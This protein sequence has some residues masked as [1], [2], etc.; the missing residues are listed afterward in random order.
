MLEW[1]YFMYCAF[2]HREIG[3]QKHEAIDNLFFI[4]LKYFLYRYIYLKCNRCYIAHYTLLS[5][6]LTALF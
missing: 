2:T 6:R 3:L 4:F 1:S 5:S